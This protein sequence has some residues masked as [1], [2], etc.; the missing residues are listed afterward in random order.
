MKHIVSR[1]SSYFPKT[2][3]TDEIELG[4]DTSLSFESDLMI[5][6]Q[7]PSCPAPAPEYFD[8]PTPCLD[9]YTPPQ[10]PLFPELDLE[11]IAPFSSLRPDQSRLRDLVDQTKVVPEVASSTTSA[12]APRLSCR[13]QFSLSCPLPIWRPQSVP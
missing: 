3:E 4:F 6:R 13:S 12:P 2:P 8:P 11:G 7:A 9:E 5:D 10:L 1:M